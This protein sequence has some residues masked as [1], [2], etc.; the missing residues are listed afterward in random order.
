MEAKI[1]KAKLQVPNSKLQENIKFQIYK[2]AIE[3]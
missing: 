2:G 1:T 3:V